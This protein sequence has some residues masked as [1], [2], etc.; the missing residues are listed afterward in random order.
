MSIMPCTECLR[1]IGKNEK[2]EE[3]KLKRR[4]LWWGSGGIILALFLSFVFW[5]SP[6]GLWTN[7]QAFEVYLEEKYKKDFVIDEI[8]FDFFNTRKYQA[9][10]YAKDD[11]ELLFYVGQDRYTGQTEDGYRYEAWSAEANEEIGAIVREHY[12]STTNYGVDLVFSETEP[13]EPVVGGY[14]KYGK[15][16]VGVTLDK[17]LLTS[18]NSKT[19][20][21]RAFLIFQELKEMGVPLHQFGISFENKTLQLHKD[22][23]SKVN[24]A[25]ELAEYLKLYRR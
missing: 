12:P 18:A 22:D 16:E 14:K 11:P 25:E 2:L 6:W 7:K 1:K 21:Q 24:S 4:F 15:V 19:E 20:M 9:Y 17:I 23:I 13:T 5:G 3:C 8:S 10:A